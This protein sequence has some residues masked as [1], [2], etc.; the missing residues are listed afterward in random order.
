MILFMIHVKPFEVYKM[1]YQEIVNETFV[2]IAAYVMLL[3]S[4]FVP[5]YDIRYYIG[6]F[7]IGLFAGNLVVNL[8]IM[9]YESCGKIK[10][11]CKKK[12]LIRKHRH[13]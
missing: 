4:E 7:H 8:S 6:W 5:D 12:Y 3:Y 11:V 1:N 9:V 13:E 10:L 2:L